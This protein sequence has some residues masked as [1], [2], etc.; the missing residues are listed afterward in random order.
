MNDYSDKDGHAE[1]VMD[2]VI[3]WCLRRAQSI[4]K[5]RSLFYILGDKRELKYALITCIER[6]DEKFKQYDIAKNFGFRLWH[7]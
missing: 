1:T 2:Y 3:L 5:Q 7:F 4:C 6:E